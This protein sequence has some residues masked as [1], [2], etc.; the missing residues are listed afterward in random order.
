MN[1]KLIISGGIIIV[2]ALIAIP[3]YIFCDVRLHGPQVVRVNQRC[4]QIVR[5]RKLI[6]Q[7]LET[8]VAALGEPTSVYTYDNPGSFTLNY[9]PH[10]SFP[11][12]KFQAHFTDSRLTGTEMF[13]D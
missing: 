6:G 12:A 13:D 10:P 3:A 7:N 4:N 2:L 1:T 8:V 11:F 5:D 9:A